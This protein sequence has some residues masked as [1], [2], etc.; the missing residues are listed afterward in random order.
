MYQTNAVTRHLYKKDFLKTLLL[1]SLPLINRKALHHEQS[2][3]AG[4]CSTCTSPQ[5][6]DRRM[7]KVI[8]SA[9]KVSSASEKK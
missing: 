4:K 1:A 7:N 8:G 6:K 3:E 9:T 5:I 2:Q